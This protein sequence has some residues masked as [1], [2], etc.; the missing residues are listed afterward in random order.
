VTADLRDVER[1]LEAVSALG[2]AETEGEAAQ[3][4]AAQAME[5]LA[6]DRVQVMCADAPGSTRFVNRGQC[7][8]P[9]PLGE[10]LVDAAAEPSGTGVAVRTGK[11]LFVADAATSPVVSPHLVDLLQPK[12]MVF[13]PLPGEGSYLG[14]V[15]AI[16][17]SPRARLDPFSQRAAELLSVEA[18]RALERT[19]ATDRLARDLGKHRDAEAS[20]HR[21]RAFLRLLNT[22]AVAAHEAATV[23]EALQR[24][25]DEVCAYTGWV[26]GHVYIPD[27]T[28]A[29]GPTTLWRL[30]DA[31]ALR[32]FR[33]VTEQTP[34][35]LGVGLPGRVAASRR[36]VWV[37]DVTADANFPR[38]GAA[39]QAGIKAALGFPVL[40]EDEVVAVLEF[41]T[42]ERLEPDE[43]LLELATHVGTQLSRVVERQR[44]EDALR[45]SEERTRAV[46]ETAGDAFIGMDDAGRVTDWNRQAEV[47]FGW[48]RPEALGRPVADLIIPRDLR[49]AHRRGL[50][51]FLTTGRSK[52]LGQRLEL[53]GRTRE[54]REFPVELTVWATEVGRSYAFSAFVHDISERKHLEAELTRQALH[55]PLTGLANR[56]LLV[57]RMAHALARAE[58]TGAPTT[59]LFLDLDGFKTVNDSLGHAAGD[60]LLVAVAERLRGSV[61]PADT[62]A[63][64]GGDEFAVLSEDAGTD[65]GTL[66]AQRIGEA[67]AAAFLVGGREVL[68]RASIG[69]ATAVPGERSADE[70]LRD[71][72]LAMYMAKRLGKGRHAVFETAMHTAALE[73]LELEADLR[74]A[75]AGSEI[76]V[77]YQ[78]IVRLADS[79]LVGMEA[80]VRWNRPGHGLVPP[81][82]FIPAAEET[83]LI[84]D[85]GRWVLEE[86]CRQVAAWQ[87]DYG[88]S[89]S[90]R[91]SV[92]LS[93]RQLQD[94]ALVG[95]VASVLDR[96][97]LDPARL[98]LEITESM[99]MEE[100]EEA[101]KR[102]QA[103]RDLGVRLAIDDFG[104]GYSSLSYLRRFPVHILKIDKAFVAAL[105]AGPE[106]AALA[107]AIVRLAHTLQ[108]GTVAE[109]IET[110]EQLAE[111]SRLG[112]EYGQGYLFAAPLP[113]ADMADL[114]RT[115]RRQG[116]LLPTM[117]S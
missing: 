32:R 80:L 49:P 16:W 60:Q 74:R 30:D 26:V 35:A 105:L 78:P 34:L 12:S 103:L 52:I 23:D 73:R 8:I 21:E 94:P 104:T 66:I 100:P 14:A 24:A 76:V 63:R 82:E 48:A 43:S 36:P 28:G 96:S 77:H 108:L 99:L 56:T 1:L 102:L 115:A 46:I 6:A 95:D 98:V 37:P 81:L 7:N 85:I 50:R 67:L 9:M 91:L 112:C 110:T 18:G 51:R 83:A 89:P 68:A 106:D 41:F 19:R 53:Q 109:G 55:D 59:V 116:T 33:E 3:L 17:N 11:T 42:Q 27:E 93:A 84:L 25:L 47:L 22:I 45:A 20:F 40:L 57:D 15:V 44:A 2:R 72:D 90:P 70:L 69:V 97:G 117:S 113:S 101:V 88:F 13:I 114:L 86:A 111:L 79:A 64:L 87:A 31:K 92:N 107:H 4:T 62:I 39:E 65:E 61:R 29:L 5:L 10:A 71:A 75:L 38:L 58:R 54:G